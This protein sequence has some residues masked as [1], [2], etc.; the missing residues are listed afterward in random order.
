MPEET[1]KEATKN[2]QIHFALRLLR[3]ARDM[4]QRQL[5]VRGTDYESGMQSP[6]EGQNTVSA[7]LGAM[8][9]R[10]PMLVR[11]VEARERTAW[12]LTNVT[13]RSAFDHAPH[14]GHAK[15][16]SAVSFPLNAPQGGFEPYF[17]LAAGGS[18]LCLADAEI[19]TGHRGGRLS[20][21]EPSPL[22]SKRK[23]EG[24]D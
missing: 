6:A 8:A 24:W 18:L 2:P 11:L 19:R 17:F 23:F 7:G 10:W 12:S 20:P 1:G 3:S 5:A 13:P 16:N 15:V 14:P 21:F 4:T 9:F 22:S